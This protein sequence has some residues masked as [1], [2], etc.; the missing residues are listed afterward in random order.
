MAALKAQIDAFNEEKSKMI[1]E[2][3]L[4]TMNNATLDLKSR[5]LEDNSLKVGDIAPFFEL[6][7]Q[8]GRSRSLKHYLSDSNLVIS[9]YRGGW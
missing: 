4:D 1:P 2:D 7:D 6:K 9:F 3:I 8:N 5:H